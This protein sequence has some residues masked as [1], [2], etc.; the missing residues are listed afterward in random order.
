MSDVKR[1]Q[2]DFTNFYFKRVRRIFPALAVTIL[3]TSVAATIILLPQDLVDYGRSVIWASAFSSNMLFWRES[4]YFAPQSLIKPLQHT[5]SLGVEE[6]FYILLP[7][8]VLIMINSIDKFRLFIL[9]GLTIG[10]FALC[11]FTVYVA[12]NAG[13][14]LLPP[15]M[16]EL[17]LGAALAFSGWTAPA[18]RWLAEAMSLI[19]LG[20]IAFGVFS[21]TDRDPYP[22]W[23]A[24]YP[25]LGAALMI[26]AGTGATSTPAANR[27]LS[28]TPMVAVGAIS[29]SLYLVHWPIAAFARYLALRG[30]TPLEAA[31]MIAASFVLAWLSWRFIEQPVRQLGLSRKRHVLTAGFAMVVAGLVVGGAAIATQGLP[32]R[33]PGYIDR[34][35][36]GEEAWGGPRCFNRDDGLDAA[37]WEATACTRIHGRHGRILLWGDSFAAQYTPGVIHDAQRIDAD[38]LQYTFTGCPPLLDYFSYAHAK[39]GPHNR[40]VPDIVRQQHIDTVVMAGRWAGLPRAEVDQLGKTVA[41]LK[42]LGVRVFVIGQSPQFP[43]DVRR[44]DY[45]SGSRMRPGLAYWPVTFD[46]SLNQH[47]ATLSAGA[48]F[49]DPLQTLCRPTDCPYRDGATFYFLDYGHFSAAGSVRAVKAYFP[50]GR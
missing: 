32:A 4:G 41:T 23:N 24:L 29:Y 46:R 43:A 45:L 39:C 40:A 50:A 31:M 35:I 36:P 10:S 28:T 25:C 22:A 18:R 8:I 3:A 15:R 13:F 34:P 9:G 16:W 44:L 6:Q 2:F 11:I 27:L 37:S 21:L 7:V 49:I 17:L 5:W 47:L 12:P 26:W 1:G 30:P 14:F 20:L 33:F 19:G 48:T 38:V 42:A